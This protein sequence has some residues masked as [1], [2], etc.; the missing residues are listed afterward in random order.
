M[1]LCCLV[2]S[3]CSP[4]LLFAPVQGWQGPSTVVGNRLYIVDFGDEHKVKAWEPERDSWQWVAG[5]RMPAAGHKPW[6]VQLTVFREHLCLV[7]PDRAMVMAPLDV[8]LSG[9]VTSVPV[10]VVDAAS[11]PE[12]GDPETMPINAVIGCKVLEA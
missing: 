8:L 2:P 3:S 11:V 4:L 7:L 9:G 1:C 12:E 6:A 5:C 10:T